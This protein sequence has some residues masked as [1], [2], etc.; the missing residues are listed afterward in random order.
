[1]ENETREKK[2]IAVIH[3]KGTM[4]KFNF[5]YLTEAEFEKSLD[6]IAEKYNYVKEDIMRYTLGTKEEMEDGNLYFCPKCGN[7]ESSGFKPAIRLLTVLKPNETEGT[8]METVAYEKYLEINCFHCESEFEIATE[9]FLEESE[10]L[11]KELQKQKETRK[12]D[13]GRN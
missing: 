5:D 4:V 12:T 9:Q 6:E 7:Y 3:T 10:Q 13:E 8:S 11:T 2:R 1:M